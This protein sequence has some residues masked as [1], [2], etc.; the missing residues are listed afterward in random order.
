VDAEGLVVDSDVE[1]R[2]GLSWPEDLAAAHGLGHGRPRDLGAVVAALRPTALLG[3][4]GVSGLFSEGIVR[5]MARHVE[6]P[7]LF[8]LS[9]PTANAEADPA[10]LLRWTEGRALVATGSPFPEVTVGGRR[11][12]V[13]QGNNAFVFPGIGLGA[14]VAEAPA[15]TDGMFAAAAN[16]LAALVDEDDLARGLVFPPMRDLRAVTVRVAE[17]VVREARDHGQGRALADAAIASAVR[18]AMWDPVYADLVP[19]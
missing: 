15:V 13:S 2:R 10:D 9:N 19:A 5:E 7:I 4:S 17:A 18:S 8:P 16:T 12:R 14:L 3:A 11:Q 6:R 1:Y